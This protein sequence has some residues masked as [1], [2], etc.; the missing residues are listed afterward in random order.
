MREVKIYYVRPNQFIWERNA[1][2][3]R[4]EY[5]VLQVQDRPSMVTTK[6]ARLQLTYCTT[7]SDTVRNT[8]VNSYFETPIFWGL[9]AESLAQHVTFVNCS[10]SLTSIHVNSAKDYSTHRENSHPMAPRQHSFWQAAFRSGG[11]LNSVL[12]KI[13]IETNN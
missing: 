6:I 2:C 8:H 3:G 5:R 12:C 11:L 9:R 10:A 13:K 4:R 7:E 1:E